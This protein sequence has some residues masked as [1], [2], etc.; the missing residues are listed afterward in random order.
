MNPIERNRNSSSFGVLA[1]ILF[2]LALMWSNIW[3]SSSKIKEREVK[4]TAIA[5]SFAESGTA[6]IVLDDEA[7]VLYWD[8]NAV[9]MFG[10]TSV[11]VVNKS[12]D[13]VV[14]DGKEHKEL[15]GD[16]LAESDGGVRIIMCDGQKKDGQ[17][18]PLSLRVQPKFKERQVLIFAD[19]V[20]AQTYTER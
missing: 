17:I 20:T 6:T 10:F 9:K 7:N 13:T 15:V 2:L 12:V 3:Q 14:P 11:E 8:E 19:L 1:V 5:Q 4:Q 18:I 16:F